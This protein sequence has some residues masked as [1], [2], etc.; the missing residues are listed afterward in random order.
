MYDYKEWQ[1]K[2]KNDID[3]LCYDDEH[4]VNNCNKSKIL[5]NDTEEIKTFPLADKQ[6]FTLEGQKIDGSISI[7]P[8]CSQIL[9]YKE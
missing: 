7:K 2:W 9:L 4:L 8:Y 5:Y 3:G 6:Y 1:E